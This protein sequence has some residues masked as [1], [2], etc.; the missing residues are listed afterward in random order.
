MP[1]DKTRRYI[2]LTK[3]GLQLV[4]KYAEE[5]YM[6]RSEVIRMVM[7][8]AAS[9]SIDKR[10]QPQRRTES[11]CFYDSQGST[12]KLKSRAHLMDVPA[13]TLIDRAIEELLN[14]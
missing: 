8:L 2:R 1:A 3:R 10:K 11:V 9:G 14:A 4:D 5:H 13:T 6:S 12:E 7:E